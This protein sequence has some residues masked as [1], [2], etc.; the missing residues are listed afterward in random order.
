[1]IFG[2]T[3]AASAAILTACEAIGVVGAACSG[4]YMILKDRDS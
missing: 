3:A 1:M 4:I 2:L